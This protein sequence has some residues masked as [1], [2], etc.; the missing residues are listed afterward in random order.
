MQNTI[1]VNTIHV[2]QHNVGF[3]ISKLYLK[4]MLDMIKYIPGNIYI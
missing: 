1:H 4:Y 2:K 3:F